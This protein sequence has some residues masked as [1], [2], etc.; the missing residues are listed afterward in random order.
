MKRSVPV[1]VKIIAVLYYISVFFAL[2][3]GYILAFKQSL[4]LEM[5]PELKAIS[6][7]LLLAF[8]ILLLAVGVLNAFVG[9]GLWKGKK[10]ARTIA[11]VF[12]I[13]GAIGALIPIFRQN[14]SRDLISI[15][16]NFLINGTIAVYL[17]FDK[18]VKNAFA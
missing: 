7:K 14:V 10:T 13:L 4:V 9:Y 3:S 5:S 6:P 8:G 1:G 11:I 18:K 15:V 17:L 2:I 16:L 12:G